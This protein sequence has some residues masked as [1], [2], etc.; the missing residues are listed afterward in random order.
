MNELFESSY[1]SAMSEMNNKL[2]EENNQLQ[3]NWNGLRE[4]L[5]DNPNVA[6]YGN[7]KD[8]ITYIELQKVLDKMN[9]LEGVDNENN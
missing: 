4:W 7:G 6:L 8:F 2:R 1:L 3:S 9:E 5:K